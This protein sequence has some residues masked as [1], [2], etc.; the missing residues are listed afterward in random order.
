MV[1]KHKSLF[2]HEAEKIN[3]FMKLLMKPRNSHEK[4]T[5]EEKKMLRS[6]LWHLSYYIPALAIFAL[7]FGSLLFPFLAEILDRRKKGRATVAMPRH[8]GSNSPQRLAQ[9]S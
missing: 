4:W 9:G 2:L 7:P 3:G 8:N 6:H 5:N 1:A